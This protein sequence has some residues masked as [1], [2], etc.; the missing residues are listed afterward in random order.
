M[1]FPSKTTFVAFASGIAIG[2]I[3]FSAIVSAWTGPTATAPAGNVAAPINVSSIDQVKN[4]NLGVNGL[5]VFGNT[6]LQGSSYLNF[7]STAGP[8]G[9]GIWDNAGVLNFKNNGGSWQT[10]QATVAALVG[11]GS[12][13]TP[14]LPAYAGWSS[15]GTGAGGAAIYNDNGSYETLMI[16]GNNSAGGNRDVKVW[17]DLYVSNSLYVGNGIHFADG[18]VQTTAASNVGVGTKVYLCPASIGCM[19]TLLGGAPCVGQLT[20]QS[21]CLYY[22]MQSST[23]VQGTTRNCTAVGHLEP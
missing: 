16:V 3:F 20:T 9:Y 2:A 5:A 14:Y 19:G 8:G 6:L 4:G 17:D 13:T 15:Q 18:S 10:I 7:G 1:R 11:A 23:C 12:L 22:Q 21:T